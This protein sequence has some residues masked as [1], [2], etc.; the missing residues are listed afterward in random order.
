MKI[1]EGRKQTVTRV[2]RPPLLRYNLRL[3]FTDFTIGKI[4][5]END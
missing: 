5:D 4:S 2:A 3:D 1:P